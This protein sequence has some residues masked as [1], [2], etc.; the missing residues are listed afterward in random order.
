MAYVKQTDGEADI[1]CGK[2]NK[3]DGIRRHPKFVCVI[4]NKK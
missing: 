2:K 1:R 4:A 3:E